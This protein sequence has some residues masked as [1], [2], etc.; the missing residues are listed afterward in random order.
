[1]RRIKGILRLPGKRIWVGG[2]RVKGKI[3]NERQ[4]RE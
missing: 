4:N 2:S 1:M 3:V